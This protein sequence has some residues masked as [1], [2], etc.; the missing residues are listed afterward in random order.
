M[1][2]LVDK[3]FENWHWWCP[4]GF[5]YDNNFVIFYFVRCVAG[6]PFGSP[7]F[8]VPVV[9]VEPWA[10]VFDLDTIVSIGDT[11]GWT[12]GFFSW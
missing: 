12:C 5:E 6:V 8:A 7:V 11:I 9:P 10:V 2:E 4:G 3:F 1:I